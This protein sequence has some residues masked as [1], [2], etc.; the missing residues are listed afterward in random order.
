[1]K[2][3]ATIHM[4]TILVGLTISPSLLALDQSIEHIRG[5]QSRQLLGDGTGVVVGV[6]D[7]GIDYTHPAFTNL[8][9]DGKSKKYAAKNFVPYESST[10]DVA[11]HGTAV[12]SIIASN[13]PNHIGLAPDAQL[14]NARVLN[15]NNGFNNGQ[16]VGNGIAYAV[17]N[18]ADI[19]NLSLNYASPNS[20]GNNMLDLMLDWAAYERNTQVVS[21]AGNIQSSYTQVRSPGSIYNGFV[22]GRT[23]ADFS[24]VHSNSANAYTQDG[25]MK[26]DLVAPGTNITIANDDH[27]YQNDYHYNS[28]YGTSFAAPHVAGLLAQQ[29][30]FGRANNLSTSNMVTKVTMMNATLHIN[31]KTGNLQKPATAFT[32]G[33][34]YTVTK[35]LSV[36]AGAGQVDGINLYN[37]YAP[38]EFGPGSVNSIGWD[39]NETGVAN[40]S[41]VEYIINAPLELDSELAVTLNWLRKVTRTDNGNSIVDINDTYTYYDLNNLDLQIL[42][43]GNI[44]AQSISI[45]DNIEQLRINIDDENAQYSLRVFGKSVGHTPESFAIAWSAVAIPEPAT[46]TLLLALSLTATARKN[47]KNC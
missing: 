18:N 16:W 22:V 33:G 24:Q 27:E 38:G 5:D 31:D 42:K 4:A 14:L 28:A 1:M 43:D 37:Q 10:N 39:L 44:I 41:H 29:L 17:N 25:R 47:R 40:N 36:D 15:N 12:A 35:P 13:D 2:S 30:E 9:T 46:L 21:I 23:T 34:V 32:Q 6:I 11:G 45:R 20:N 3:A 8:T 26:P 7:S 19:L